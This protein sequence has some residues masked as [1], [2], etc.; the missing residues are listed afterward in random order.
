MR[1]QCS[2]LLLVDGNKLAHKHRAV[3]KFLNQ[4]FLARQAE[5]SNEALTTQKIGLGANLTHTFAFI[6][7][8]AKKT[9]FFFLSIVLKTKSK[10]GAHRDVT[11]DRHV[12]KKTTKYT[13]II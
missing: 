1:V 5:T 7:N 12:K 9:Q 6:C 2:K 8:D 11:R 13:I 3:N 4:V 10:A